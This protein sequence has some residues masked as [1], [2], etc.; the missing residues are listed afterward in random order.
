MRPGARS[1]ATS[2]GTTAPDRPFQINVSGY[3]KELVAKDLG[4]ARAVVY[5]PMLPFAG[6]A[7]R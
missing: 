6:L 3:A 7:Q 1:L 2:A 5:D 4:L